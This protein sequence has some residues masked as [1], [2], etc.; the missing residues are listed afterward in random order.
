[1]SADNEDGLLS[2]LKDVRRIQQ[3]Q[4]AAFNYSAFAQLLTNQPKFLSCSVW[5]HL[6]SSLIDSSMYG[7][8]GPNP[9]G[10]RATCPKTQSQYVENKGIGRDATHLMHTHMF[11]CY[12][13]IQIYFPL[14]IH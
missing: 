5:H 3:A 13:S 7:N 14:D 1:M 12:K 8:Y 4:Y 2:A 9:N 10:S 6:S 11:A